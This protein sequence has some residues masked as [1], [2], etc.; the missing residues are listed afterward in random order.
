MS[1]KKQKVEEVLTG[2][3]TSFFGHF[4]FS[5]FSLGNVHSLIPSWE[6]SVLGVI[7]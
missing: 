3:W 7:H 5:P 1:G 2:F 6:T 4:F